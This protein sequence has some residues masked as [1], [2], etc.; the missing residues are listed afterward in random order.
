MSSFLFQEVL[1]ATGARLV[2]GDGA[3]RLHGV[4]TDTRTLQEGQLYLALAGP[5]FDGNHFAA[6]ACGR[7]AGGLLLRATDDP[8]EAERCAALPG[9]APLATVADPLAA[10]SALAAWH[11]ARLDVPVLGITGSCG[12]TT[13]KNMVVELLE[14][15]LRVVGSPA[16]FNN[17]I[18]VPHT[19]LLADRSTEV[20]VVEMGTNAPG[21]I[22]ALC[23]TARPTCAIITNVGASHLEG[24]GSVEG[25][26]REKGG[27]AA[28]VPQD[29]FVV[30]NADCRF[31]PLLRSLTSAKV[32]TFSIDGSG[33]LNASDVWFH[34]GGTTFTLD[35]ERSVTVPLLGLHSVQNLLA[36]M[37]ACRGLGL[38][39][40]QVLPSVGRLRA[41]RQR[42]EPIEVG[43]LTL[44]DDSYNAN[45]ESAR[46]SVRVLAGLHGFERRVLV[47]GEMHE[48]GGASKEM[49]RELGRQAAQAG[50]DL[51][52]TVGAGAAPTAV[53]ALAEGLASERVVHTASLE[54]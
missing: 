11:R 36:A 33:D 44:L 45:P 21:E 32:I 35:G 40:D 1:D 29:G 46:A 4:S 20:L 24:L 51:L 37:A 28:A 53:G 10:L 25:V 38:P 3:G 8:R 54:E 47:M 41:G 50:V 42:L 27:L 19:L 30:L 7:G 23:Q 18:G 39:L 43:G 15:H 31:T 14:G 13:T 2:R 49:H 48:L 22:Q 12:K 5:N 9:H 17:E 34:R 6:D 16:S 52:V 26:A